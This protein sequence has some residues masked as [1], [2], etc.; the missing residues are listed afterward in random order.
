LK[1]YKGRAGKGLPAGKKDADFHHNKMLT[2]PQVL[3]Y[4]RRNVSLSIAMES[5]FREKKEAPR[6]KQTNKVF[7]C[8]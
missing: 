7:I 6:A 1:V 4:S 5:F 3:T 8:R 2:C